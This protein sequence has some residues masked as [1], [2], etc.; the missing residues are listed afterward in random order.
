MAPSASDFDTLKT[1]SGS[2]ASRPRRAL[3]DLWPDFRR[4][5]KSSELNDLAES[6]II[7]APVAKKS[8]S[9]MDKIAGRRLDRG[10]L[11]V[12]YRSSL[13]GGFSGRV[14]AKRGPSHLRFAIP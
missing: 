10:I 3:A 7:F 2:V 11:G 6:F 4:F 9:P 14:A 13:L 8:S 1:R 12:R 5:D